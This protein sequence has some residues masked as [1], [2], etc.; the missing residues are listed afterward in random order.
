MLPRLCNLSKSNS[1]FL[2]GPRGTGKTT[3][4]RSQFPDERAVY[5]NLLDNALM[6]QLLLDSSR[7]VDLID[8]AEHRTKAVII[9]EVQKM[10]ELLNVAHTQIQE[11]KRQFILTGSSSRKLKQAGANLLAGRAW[12][13]HLYPLN[14]LEMSDAFDLKRALELGGLPE[15][16]LSNRDD[17]RE[18][19]NSYVATY[20]QKE[21][22]QEQWVKN[23][24]PFRKFLA[25]SAQMNGKIIN[26]A[27]IAKQVGVDP[28]TVANYFE[29]L[30]DTL[31]GFMLPAF[32]RSVRKAQ[33]QLPKF[34]YVDTGIKR[35][36]DRTL[37]V[38]LLPQTFAWGDAFEHWVILEFVK[39]SQYKRLDWSFS[40]IRT[41]D[42]VE[43]DLIVERPG[44]R[45][46]F[47]EI[48]S[49][50]LV[51]A[52]DAKSLETLGADTDPKAERWLLS[53]DPL[54]RT[55]G[56][57]KAMHWMDGIKL[58]FS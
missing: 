45:N 48:K 8:S 38:E 25:I 3:L 24:A 33:R 44:D 12:L 15:A 32:S 7:F 49:K 46:L 20:L 13:Y 11:R 54:Q 5:V 19:L 43:I 2:F 18:Y 57:T 6:D 56:K 37:S 30:E 29:I 50:S 4:I 22:Q 55:F 14:A 39:G 42:D 31:I 27:A 9:D 53:C 41:K 17:A 10:P 47:V 21:I 26:K 40:Y 36:L 1:F 28:T 16:F 58:L 35:G 34:Y 51:D 23:L 52:A